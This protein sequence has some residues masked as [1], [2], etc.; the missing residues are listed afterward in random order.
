MLLAGCILHLEDG[1]YLDHDQHL[2]PN[3]KVFYLDNLQAAPINGGLIL[4]SF[5]TSIDQTRFDS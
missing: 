1:I 2:D 3:E 5:F 4:A